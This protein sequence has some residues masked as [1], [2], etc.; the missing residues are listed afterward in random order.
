[1]EAVWRAVAAGAILGFRREMYHVGGTVAGIASG[2]RRHMAVPTAIKHARDTA[3][4]STDGGAANLPAAGLPGDDVRASLGG[5]EA[6]HD[7]WSRDPERKK[8]R[9]DG[10]LDRA[11]DPMQSAMV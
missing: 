6:C 8:Q 10:K 5:G 1:M 11:F 2:A 9:R 3:A 7:L 4:L